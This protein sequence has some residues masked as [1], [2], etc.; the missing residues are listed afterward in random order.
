M[1]TTDTLRRTYSHADYLKD[2]AKLMQQW[3]DLLDLICCGFREI[4]TYLADM[5]SLATYTGDVSQN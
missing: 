3:A 4:A 2:R 1:E 5:S